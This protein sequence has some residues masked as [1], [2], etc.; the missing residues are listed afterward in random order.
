[1]KIETRVPGFE[2]ENTQAR[3]ICRAAMRTVEMKKGEKAKVNGALFCRNIYIL[4][5]HIPD[6]RGV[7]LARRDELLGLCYRVR[8]RTFGACGSGHGTFLSIPERGLDG[9]RCRQP[10]QTDLNQ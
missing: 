6:V 4:Q 1:M 5:G 2:L 8:D 3:W 7:K 10:G 9:K